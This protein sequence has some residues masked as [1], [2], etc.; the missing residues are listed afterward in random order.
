[1]RL[2]LLSGRCSPLRPFSVCATPA[3]AHS[4]PPGGASR[5]GCRA[6][7]SSG[8]P[9]LGR[10]LQQRLQQ[11]GLDAGSGEARACAREGYSESLLDSVPPRRTGGSGGG[12][13][14]GAASPTASQLIEAME[15]LGLADG[16]EIDQLRAAQGD[17]LGLGAR[18]PGD[19]TRRAIRRPTAPRT[20]SR[21]FIVDS[22]GTDTLRLLDP[23]RLPDSTRETAADSVRRRYGDR[24]ADRDSIARELRLREQRAQRDSGLRDSRPGPVL[25]RH[26]AVRRELRRTGRPQ[27]P[28][29]ARRPPAA[30]ADGRRRAGDPA[31]RDPGGLRADPAG[32]AAV[33]REP[34]ARAVRR[35]AVLAARARVLR[36]AARRRDDALLRVGRAAAQQSGVRDRRRAAAG[37]LPRVERGHRADRAVRGRRPV[38]GGLA[39]AH[40]GSPRGTRRRGPR[41]LRLSDSRRRLAGRPTRIGDVVFVPPRLARVRALGEV[42]RPA[43][44]ELKPERRL[45]TSCAPRVA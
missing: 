30:R 41:R 39:A 6:P 26:V 38:R 43:T 16:D 14:S 35:P 3:R 44:Y 9:D 2:R 32:R 42:L 34:H 22:V 45:R 13:R 15:V 24:A 25:E 19:T 31:E 28:A 12:R 21:D 29:R 1:M 33:R 40:R 37:Q 10:Q 5:R 4:C 23:A 17:S 20:G 8:N 7:R 18:L 27:L 11:S 36:G